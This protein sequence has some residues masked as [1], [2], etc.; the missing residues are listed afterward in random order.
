MS[1]CGGRPSGRHCSG[2]GIAASLLVVLMIAAGAASHPV[3]HA[4]DAAGRV[5]LEV[6]AVT[7]IAVASAAVLGGAAYAMWRAR[8]RQHAAATAALRPARW[9]RP[10]RRPLPSR[11]PSEQ[12]GSVV[13]FGPTEEFPPPEELRPTEAF[14]PDETF[15]PDEGLRPAGDFSPILAPSPTLE[16]NAPIAHNAVAVGDAEGVLAPQARDH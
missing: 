6:L 1:K 16:P 14:R 4:A 8:R 7:A 12:R 3:T 11:N 5:A 15:R 13:E 9:P 10:A 2:A